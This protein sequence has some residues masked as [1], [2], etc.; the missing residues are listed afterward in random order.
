M[1]GIGAG[2]LDKRIQ[3]MTLVKEDNGLEVVESYKSACGSVWAKADFLSD[4]ER[5]RAGA[6]Q[7]IASVRFT[8]RKREVSKTWRIRYGGTDYAIEGI[9]PFARDDAFLEITAGEVS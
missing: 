7:S 8:I 5:F 9:K 6:V 3:F 2:K 1:S 4:S